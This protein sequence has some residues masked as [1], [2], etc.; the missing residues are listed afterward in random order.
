MY[1][2]LNV[3]NATATGETSTYD[4]KTYCK[5]GSGITLTPNPQNGY[6]SDGWDVSASGVTVTGNSFTMPSQALTV[7][8]KYKPINY[9]ITYD[10]DGGT[11][12]NR[13]TYNIEDNDI[14]LSNPTKTG[15]DF[16]GWSG[17]GLTG[18]DNKNVTISKGSTGH[19]TYQAHWKDIVAPTGLISIGD[20][21]WDIFSSNPAFL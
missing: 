4:S 6:E 2:L 12:G 1:Y 9:T 19:R 18:N 5:A 7:T 8:A 3:N 13:E 10:L 11:A 14:T 16:T 20:N 17:T 21:M 15:Y